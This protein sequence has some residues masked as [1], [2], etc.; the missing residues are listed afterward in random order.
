MHMCNIFVTLTRTLISPGS[1][2]RTVNADLPFTIIAR[3]SHGRSVFSVER[4][5]KCCGGFY[6]CCA[7]CSPCKAEAR[8]KL[9]GHYIG[10][11]RQLWTGLNTKFSVEDAVGKDVF[12]IHEL[13]WCYAENAQYDVIDGCCGTKVC[14]I[15]RLEEG[16]GSV[17]NKYRVDFLESTSTENKVLLLGAC[18]LFDF[19][20]HGYVHPRHNLD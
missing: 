12:R 17:F 5:A 10:A 4:A 2:N 14:V 19:T 15:G 9:A 1:G 3:D 11:V 6:G 20:F 7:C 16:F 8:V 18:V 13:Q